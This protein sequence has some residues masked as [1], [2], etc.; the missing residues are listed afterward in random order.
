M[1]RKVIA[2][3]SLIVLASCGIILQDV[4]QPLPGSASVVEELEPVA[5]RAEQNRMTLEPL[6]VSVDSAEAVQAAAQA[7]AETSVGTPVQMPASEA[8]IIP[9][10]NAASASAPAFASE[11][12]NPVAETVAL[13]PAQSV[14]KKQ[15]RLDSLC[16]EIGNK[17]GS[18][19]ITDCLSQQLQFADGLSVNQRALV[20]KEFLP[21]DG[22][23]NY[24]RV[25]VIGGIHG[26]EYSSISILFKW[27]QI[28]ATETDSDFYWRLLPLMNPD[29]LL[30]GTAVRQTANGVDLNRNFPTADWQHS[31]LS[32][33]KNS[34]GSN[35][36]RF[37]GHA[38]ATEP[39]TQWLIRQI[40]EFNPVVIISVHAPHGLLDFDGPTEAPQKI[41]QLHLY[42]LGVYPG[43]LG[44]YGGVDLGVPVIT[45]ELASAGI[46]PAERDIQN[47]WTDLNKWLIN[48]ATSLTAVDLER[49]KIVNR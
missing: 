11:E 48:N 15:A 2:S 46:M 7:V 40:E 18:V 28:R 3:L 36:R 38:P 33:W 29:G 34:T 45:L 17:L 16:K 9:D 25:L 39:E 32:A 27:M 1:V 49:K 21:A 37:P 47:M 41:G 31:A 13:L 8:A 4:K 20:K 44:N 35:P 26:D 5:A 24:P 23:T 30:D 43:S 22:G 42:R 10:S 14:N 12:R 6:N 19:S